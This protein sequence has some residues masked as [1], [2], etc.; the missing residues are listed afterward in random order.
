M[1]RRHINNQTLAITTN[2]TIKGVS[3]NTM[4]AP[5]NKL[6]PHKLGIFK[7]IGLTGFNLRSPFFLQQ[8]CKQSLLLKTTK[9][10][11][12]DLV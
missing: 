11:E 3:N 2:N 8:F 6:R 5:M 7:K 1:A 10:F 12:V 9:R 4:M